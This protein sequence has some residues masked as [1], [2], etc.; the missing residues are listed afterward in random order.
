M[1]RNLSNLPT[2][3]GFMSTSG[4]TSAAAALAVG[5]PIVLRTLEQ[6]LAAKSKSELLVQETGSDL[7][8]NDGR[9]TAHCFRL[10]P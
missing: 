8:L 3:G 2:A 4:F 9:A 10:D 5:A 6:V 7:P 1:H